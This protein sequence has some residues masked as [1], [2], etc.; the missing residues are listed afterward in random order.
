MPASRCIF[1]TSTIASSS[2]AVERGVV[3]P[4]VQ[5]IDARFAQFVGTYEAAAMI[6]AE[7]SALS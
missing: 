2:I 5:A 4:A 1:S 7:D 6:G 3:D